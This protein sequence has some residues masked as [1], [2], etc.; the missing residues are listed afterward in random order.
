MK[1]K[2]IIFDID[3]VLLDSNIYL[4]KVHQKTAKEMGLRI[5]TIHEILR[6]F[7]KDW[8]SLIQTL[9]PGIDSENFKK[10]YSRV[11][12]LENVTIPPIKKAVETIKELKILGFKL[13]IVSA[14]PG[15]YTIEPLKKSGFDLELFD[16]VI[17]ADDTKNHKPNPEPLTH[18]CKRLNIDPKEAVY[19]G[20]ALIDYESANSAKL[21][22]I[23][24]LTGDVKEEEFR[25]NGVKNIIPSV[26]ELPKFLKL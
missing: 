18:T 22:F 5:P 9:W 15:F 21:E 4:A 11:G 3:G 2:T 20:D 16:V 8:D 26:A 1:I 24:V 10:T 12:N 19:V 7:G 14:R 13:A 23:A 17:S 6:L 25:N